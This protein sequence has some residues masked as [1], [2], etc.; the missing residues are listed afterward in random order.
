MLQA[1]NL[2]Y[3][4]KDEEI[5]SN[6]NYKFEEGKLYAIIGKS[7]SGKTTL[8]SL[9]SGILNIQSGGII[10][11]N[12]SIV[13][14]KMRDYRASNSIIFQSFNL[15]N[16]LTP[17][18]NVKLA[19]EI[20]EVQGNHND[21]AQSTLKSVGLTDEQS[22]RKC[23]ELSGGQQQRVAIARSLACDSKIIFADEPTGNLDPETTIEI[24][25]LLVR[26]TKEQNKCVICV[27]HDMEL[28]DYADRVIK[29]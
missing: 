27:T 4:Y 1:K 22:K 6:F 28:K 23:R 20:T 12:K 21:I 2:T 13:K 19:L 8:L 7:G 10:F 17:I 5:L 24:I 29:L 9:L 14:E 25:H 3:K 26:L 16:Y 11:N 15:I 18:E